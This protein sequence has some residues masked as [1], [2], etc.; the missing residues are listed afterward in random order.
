MTSPTS[1]TQGFAAQSIWFSADT[2]KRLAYSASAHGLADPDAFAR[3]IFPVFSHL[4]RGPMY[5]GQLIIDVSGA[6][7]NV[8][9]ASL[10]DTV[11]EVAVAAVGH[12]GQSGVGCTVVE[13]TL[14]ALTRSDAYAAR[15]TDAL[16][17]L[18]PR[19][20]ASE[21]EAALERAKQRRAEIARLPRTVKPKYSSVQT[22]AS[23]ALEVLRVWLPTLTPGRH[24]FGDVYAS[25]AATCAQSRARL[26]EKHLEAAL[27]IGRNT[28]YRL[29][30]QEAKVSRK[31][32]VSYVI[33]E[34]TKPTAPQESLA[35]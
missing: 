22:P 4:R 6:P 27:D 35:D 25:F 33:V 10:V 9:R 20:S 15:I 18:L 7:S 2:L 34:V 11:Q 32:N 24:R 1:T 16:R 30:N 28:F 19:A 8:T 14:T 3:A 21:A 13:C 17:R 12:L 31:A 26:E 5:G 23:A 29:L